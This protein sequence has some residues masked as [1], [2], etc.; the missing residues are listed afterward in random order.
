MRAGSV[1]RCQ[2]REKGGTEKERKKKRGGKT[3]GEKESLARQGK[4]TES[5]GR[6]A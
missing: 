5:C 1:E 2:E 3:A 4:G 6:K